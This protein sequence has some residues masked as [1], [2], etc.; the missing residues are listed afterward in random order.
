MFEIGSEIRETSGK[1]KRHK[2]PDSFADLTPDQ[3]VLTPEQEEECRRIGE[4]VR[5]VFR[6]EEEAEEK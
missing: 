6:G 2:L 3:L 1:T 5:A 4:A